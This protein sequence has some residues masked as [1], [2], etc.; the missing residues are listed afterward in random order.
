MLLT[1]YKDDPKNNWRAKDTAIYLVTT[2]AAKGSTQKHGVT[3]ASQL[4]PLPQFCQSDII[5]EL[6]RQD[7]NEFP[8]L[9]AD[10][11]KFLMTFR[12]VLGGQI[13]VATI[14][15]IIRHLN[16]ENFVVHSYA[17]CNLEKML[18]MKDAAGNPLITQEVLAPFAV[19][20][21]GGLFQVRNFIIIND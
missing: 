5:P 18:I 6:E 16:A 13:L 7:I 1:R 11:L 17:S 14:P 21:I 4:V 2:L 20:V 12:S 19:D 9:K 3:Q 15:Q 10:A 8:V